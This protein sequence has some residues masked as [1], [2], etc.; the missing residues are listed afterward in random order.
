MIFGGSGLIG[1]TLIQSSQLKKKY[2]LFNVD[3]S[4]KKKN[5]FN[6]K[7]D[8]LNAKQVENKIKT[9]SKSHGP[10]YGVINTT[11]PKVQQNIKNQAI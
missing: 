5:I 6:H 10:I 11:Y 3:L 8:V 2:L 9:I 1:K 4:I 7:C